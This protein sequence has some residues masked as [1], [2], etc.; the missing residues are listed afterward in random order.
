MRRLLII[1]TG[2][3]IVSVQTTIAQTNETP[4]EKAEKCFASGEWRD[5]LKYTPHTSIDKEMF[6]TQYKKNKALWDKAFGFLRVTN[7]DSIKPGKY[8]I[9]GDSVFASVTESPTKEMSNSKW[10]FHKKYVDLQMVIKGTEK[11]GAYDVTKINITDPYNETKD[12]GFGTYA[13]GDYYVA[14]AGTFFLFFPAHAHRPSLKVEGCDKDKKIVIKIL[15][16]N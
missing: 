5:G 16:A 3:L 10:E 15:Y 9:V 14:E 4:K 11:M 8:P 13:E 1:L 7:L 12:I 6:G 2:I